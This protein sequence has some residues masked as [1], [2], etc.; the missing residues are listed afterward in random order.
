MPAKFPFYAKGL[1]LLFI[2]AFLV[3]CDKEELDS[4]GKINSSIS[5]FSNAAIQGKITISDAYLNLERIEVLGT[6]PTLEVVSFSQN[7][8]DND[9]RISLTGITPGLIPITAKRN[10]YE[11]FSITLTLHNEPYNLLMESFQGENNTVQET[12]NFGDFL[13]NAI[14]A[15]FIQGKFD[16]R[17]KSIPVY[18]AI[19]D[20]YPLRVTGKQANTPQVKID[21]EN[22]AEVFINPAYLLQNI[23]TQKLEQADKLFH[24]QQEIIFIHPQFNS[25]LYRSILDRLEDSE[26]SMSLKVTVTKTAQKN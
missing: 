4:N 25:E 23:T 12:V 6:S 21:L 13:Q 17:G 1:I 22:R 11:P 8:S 18:I 14:P 26:N 10:T 20:T 15:L 9:S 16:N 3:Q 19:T 5:L 2:S 7:I 24:Q